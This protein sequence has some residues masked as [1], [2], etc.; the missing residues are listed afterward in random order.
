MLPSSSR[1]WRTGDLV[2][3]GVGTAGAPRLTDDHGAAGACSTAAAPWADTAVRRRRRPRA[4][5]SRATGVSAIR[6][7]KSDS[8]S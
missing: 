7:L 2:R 3:V 4:A 1:P 8:A 5:G 6:W